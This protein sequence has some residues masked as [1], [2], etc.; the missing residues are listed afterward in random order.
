M[1]YVQPVQDPEQVIR[2]CVTPEAPNCTCS[3]SLFE[4]HFLAHHGKRDV[5]NHQLSRI[6][7]VP[8]EESCSAQG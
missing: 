7:T 6:C 4:N 1:G 8:Q 3:T 5:Y 2:R